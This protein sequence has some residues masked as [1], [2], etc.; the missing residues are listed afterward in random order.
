MHFTSAAIEAQESAFSLP[1]RSE[2]ALR[3]LHA[4]CVKAAPLSSVP[5]NRRDTEALA[6][7]CLR[8]IERRA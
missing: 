8:E 6:L 1:H 7:A 3:R 5:A 2:T 4:H